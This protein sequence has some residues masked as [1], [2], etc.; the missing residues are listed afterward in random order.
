M[1]NQKFLLALV[2]C[3]M[4]VMLYLRTKVQTPASLNQAAPAKTQSAQELQP[5]QSA[6]AGP[7]VDWTQTGVSQVG[8]QP[9]IQ[10]A[11]PKPE[12]P[13][14][15]TGPPAMSREKC[16]ATYAKNAWPVAFYAKFSPGDHTYDYALCHAVAENDPSYCGMTP[17]S[18]EGCEFNVR[19]LRMLASGMYGKFDMSLCR[20]YF[21]VA[22]SNVKDRS[23]VPPVDTI[24]K[25][26]ADI[27]AGRQ[28]PTGEAAK[29]FRFLNGNCSGQNPQETLSCQLLAD[30]AAGLKTGKAR[31]WLYD[32]VSG[33]GCEKVDRPLV[34]K[35]CSGAIRPPSPQ[36]LVMPR[37]KNSPASGP[38]EEEN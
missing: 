36:T 21:N 19:N 4:G 13:P 34:E 27:L 37:R 16:L 18:K 24:C 38:S 17:N 31:M 14:E 22:L 10:A 12:P 11:A 20:D 5:E 35:Y 33:K 30:L 3:L 7:T 6:D 8:R 26:Y 15:V 28:A 9:D 29:H 1:L 23:K 25:S 2:V 32:A